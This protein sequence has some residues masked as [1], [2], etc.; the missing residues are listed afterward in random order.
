[1]FGSIDLVLAQGERN[2]VST[3]QNSTQRIAH[4]V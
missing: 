2:I 1:L 3:L 4:L